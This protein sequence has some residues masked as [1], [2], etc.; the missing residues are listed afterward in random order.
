[1]PLNCTAIETPE[2]SNI[3]DFSP[4]QISPLKLK[5]PRIQSFAK[6]QSSEVSDKHL[7]LE[8]SIGSLDLSK[9]DDSSTTQP[10]ENET[11]NDTT[12]LS[13]KYAIALYN[14]QAQSENEIDLIEG[15]YVKIE[16]SGEDWTEISKGELRGRVPSS[17][18]EVIVD[19]PNIDWGK[20]LARPEKGRRF[21]S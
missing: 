11:L 16:C 6:S 17:Y 8:Q 19:D 21:D 9:P 4:G 18:V 7:S 14:Y 13:D 2:E 12:V 1:M 20:T 5:L 10:Q 15:D 3:L